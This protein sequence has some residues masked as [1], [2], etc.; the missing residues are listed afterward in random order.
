MNE[1]ER[2]YIDII[3]L[4]FG[5][6]EAPSCWIADGDRFYASGKIKKSKSLPSGQ[7]TVEY[8]SSIRGYVVTKVAV[9][10][11]DL[12]EINDQTQKII[13]ES[14]DFFDKIP[15]F[16]KAGF[17]PKRGILLHGVPGQ[18]KTSTCTIIANNIIKNNGIVFSVTNLNAFENTVSFL[19]TDFRSVEKDRPIIVIIEDI[20]IIADVAESQLTN[21][22]DGQSS[23]APAIFIA[24]TNRVDELPDSLLRP[25]RFDWVVEMT[26]PSEDNIR[27]F[28]EQKGIVDQ[29]LEDF[30]KASNGMTMADVKELFVTVKLLGGSIE[31]TVDRLKGIS[32][33]AASTVKKSKSLK[34]TKSVG[35]GKH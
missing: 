2:S 33:V 11:D 10:S 5:P 34:A 1:P 9:N 26:N 24:T 19:R 25:S 14:K 16:K 4:G 20:D 22:I 8:D 18:G 32:K 30:V 27:T 31:D 7:Y 28:F 21:F 12:I 6:E 15:E 29:E 35:F 3:D 17:L 23:V 13:K